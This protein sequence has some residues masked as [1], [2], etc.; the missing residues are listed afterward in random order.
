MLK[1]RRQSNKMLN[2]WIH[3]VRRWRLIWIGNWSRWHDMGRARQQL[4]CALLAREVAHVV[5]LN[6]L[7]PRRFRFTSAHECLAARH[8]IVLIDSG[9]SNHVAGSKNSTFDRPKISQFEYSFFV[10]RPRPKL[11]FYSIRFRAKTSDFSFCLCRPHFPPIYT[12][13]SDP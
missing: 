6:E 9:W 10:Y 11:R 1:P 4:S 12:S 13:A 2:T 5:R 8:R 7:S 3:Q